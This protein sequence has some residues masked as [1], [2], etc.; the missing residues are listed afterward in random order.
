VSQGT[1]IELEIMNTQIYV[2]EDV[3]HE[4]ALSISLSLAIPTD[5]WKCSHHVPNETSMKSTNF[6][7]R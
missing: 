2:S 6:L 5:F 4:N 1:T 7:E 3:N